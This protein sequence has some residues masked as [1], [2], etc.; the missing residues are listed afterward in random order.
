M[1][2]EKI[3]KGEIAPYVY[4]YPTPRMFET[5]EFGTRIHPEFTEELN[6]YIHIPFCRQKCTWC[7]YLTVIE[8]KKNAEAIQEKYV[9]CIVRE[10]HLTQDTLRRSKITSINFGGGTPSLL[11][12]IQ[13]A[14]IMM[15]LVLANPQAL[16]ADEVSIEATPESIESGKIAAFQQF[17]LN[18]VS[19]GVES[20][21][22]SEIALSNRHNTSSQSENTLQ[23]LKELNVPNVCV[24]LMYGLP[25][26]TVQSWK[27][28]LQKLVEIRPQTV[29]LY[30]TSSV[31]GTSFF[32]NQPETMSP[33]E[34]LDCYFL[35]RQALLIAGYIQ[36]CHMRFVLPNSEGGYVQQANVMKGQS[37]IGFGVGART[38]A[39]NLHYRNVYSAKN[40]KRALKQYMQTVENWFLPITDIAEISQED[41]LRQFVIYNL[42]HLDRKQVRR[43]FD[44]NVR[45]HFRREFNEIIELGLAEDDGKIIRLTP[46]GLS[47]RDLIA[48][49]FFSSEA[50]KKEVMYRTGAMAA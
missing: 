36:D 25:G 20:F 5:S 21:I 47:H 18:R 13:F 45:N 34:M 4:L 7:G 26:Q 3:E 15:A 28:S 9:D 32:R 1:L 30:A 46:K 37:L 50:K 2:R 27:E 10:I 49:E 23:T 39:K 24:D 16:E 40:P 35:A 38:Y 11:T 48:R 31:E 42:E 19:V 17:G 14:R 44:L 8:N 33:Q 22:D 6:V 41:R 12:P 29:E 43:I